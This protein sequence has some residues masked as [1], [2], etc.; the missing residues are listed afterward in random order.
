M[1]EAQDSTDAIPRNAQVNAGDIAVHRTAR[2][3]VEAAR[4]HLPR[5]AVRA[6]KKHFGGVED[7]GALGNV[8]Q[9][10]ELGH[11]SHR[12]AARGLECRAA[13]RGA[14]RRAAME[15]AELWVMPQTRSHLLQPNLGRYGSLSLLWSPTPNAPAH[16][17]L[18]AQGRKAG[19]SRANIVCS[20]G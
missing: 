12:V 10:G 17:S 15:L 7:R 20:C 9:P 6:L 2:E 11:V 8:G 5:D 4:I 1:L 16:H 14:C 18:G 3:R 19:A 13:A